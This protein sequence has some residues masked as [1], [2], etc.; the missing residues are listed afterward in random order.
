[1]T[2]K[3]ESR[4]EF[5]AFIKLPGGTSARIVDGW[6]GAEGKLEITSHAANHEEATRLIEEAR[7]RLMKALTE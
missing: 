1:M 2:I 5:V 4:A 3:T 6:G 7:R